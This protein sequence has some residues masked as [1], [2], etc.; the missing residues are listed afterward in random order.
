[1]RIAVI[2]AGAIGGTIAALLDRAGHDVAI[3]ARGEQLETIRSSGL[4]ISGGWGEHTA[5]PRAS[6][7]LDVTPELAFVCTKAQDAAG[8]IT[9]N[10]ESLAGIPV[11]IVQNG[12]DG[13][14]LAEEMLPDSPVIGAIAIY[15]ASY[16]KPGLIEVT[17]AGP[18]VIGTDH[19]ARREVAAHVSSVLRAAMPTLLVTDFRGAQ[20][21]KLIVNQV[22]AMPAITGLSAQETLVHPVLGRIVTASMREAVRIGFATGVRFASL[23]GMSQPILRA[24]AIAPIAIG[25]VLP[26]VMA[27]RMGDT[28]NPGSTLQ[29]IRRGQ[30]TEIDFLN[31]AVVR[32]AAAAGLT[33]PINE[34]LTELVHR[35]EKSGDFLGVEEVAAEF[36]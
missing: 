3:T 25:R 4:R 36:A 14:R 22:N 19:P 35:V 17:A 24:F 23:Q 6:A 1:M 31:G 13:V 26:R 16:L 5:R 10:A 9:A 27:A 34:K 33:A 11:V 7:V 18:T 32:A 12:L 8:A 28:P 30:P 21:S 20:W 2:G 29:S 15:A